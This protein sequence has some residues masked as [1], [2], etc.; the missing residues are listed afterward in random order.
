MLLQW[1]FLPSLGLG[2]WPHKK[3]S[4]AYHNLVRSLLASPLSWS[5]PPPQLHQ[6]G[7]AVPTH[8]SIET[9]E[10]SQVR[11]QGDGWNLPVCQPTMQ[12]CH[13]KSDSKSFTP[14]V[15]T[16]NILPADTHAS[17]S[18]RIKGF[19]NLSQHNDVTGTPV[20]RLL[21]PHCLT[22]VS[23]GAA[24]NPASKQVN[25]LCSHDDVISKREPRLLPGP[26]LTLA[27]TKNIKGSS[28]FHASAESKC[29]SMGE[30]GNVD[31]CSTD[32][33]IFPQKLPGS[34]PAYIRF[35]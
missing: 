17:F 7:H 18:P 20:L 22:G 2:A 5:L 10:T 25:H 21:S 35:P 8:H 24:P 33:H 26:C 23:L 31:T 12:Q 32:G 3:A 11:E 29:S 14:P 28:Q 16:T 6:E 19:N 27:P 15:I 30:S 34:G 4:P 9:G 1:L 13:I